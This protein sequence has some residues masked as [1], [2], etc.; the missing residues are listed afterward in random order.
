MRTD[1][2]NEVLLSSLGSRPP[3]PHYF[4]LECALTGKESM[5]EIGCG[6]GLLY[7]YLLRRGQ[8]DYTGAD[9]T[10]EMLRAFRDKQPSV[11]TLELDVQDMG[12]VPSSSYDWV[13][14]ADVLIHIPRPFVALENLWRVTRGGLVLVVRTSD[15]PE[16]LVNVTR[17]YQDVKGKHYYYNVFNHAKLLDRFQAFTPAPVAIDAYRTPLKEKP[18]RKVPIDRA[19]YDVWATNFAILKDGTSVRWAGSGDRIVDAP[20]LSR[21]VLRRARAFLG[22]PNRWE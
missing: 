8:L 6:P 9:L 15:F 3:G 20:K 10:D 1:W 22:M 2:S 12:V 21:R 4:Y 19:R 7:Q 17:S 14:C 18:A 13:V 5:L 16:D 11:K